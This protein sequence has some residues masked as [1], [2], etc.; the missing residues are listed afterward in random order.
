MNHEPAISE[1]I[2]A[3]LL[4]GVFVAV[5]MVI[6][7]QIHAQYP[8]PKIPETQFEITN[9]ETTVWVMQSG[10][11][12]ISVLINATHKDGSPPENLTQSLIFM[13]TGERLEYPIKTSYQSVQV[14]YND[15][16]TGSRRLMIEKKLI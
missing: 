4:S 16:A 3:L 12:N 5:A 14:V 6:L 13:K 10:G 7:S 11:E 2:G 9:N 15:Q 8:P 1:L